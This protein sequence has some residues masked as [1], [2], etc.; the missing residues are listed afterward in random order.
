MVT[1]VNPAL[2]GQKGLIF[3]IFNGDLVPTQGWTRVL[4]F[5]KI[6]G[7]LLPEGKYL[8]NGLPEITSGLKESD[9]GD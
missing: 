3:I 7:T 2:S 6:S 5:G 1:L 9:S 8:K 4:G